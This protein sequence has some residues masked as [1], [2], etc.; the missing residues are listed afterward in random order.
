M[1]NETEDDDDDCGFNDNGADDDDDDNDDDDDD[2]AENKDDDDND[3]NDDDGSDCIDDEGNF[4]DGVTANGDVSNIKHL[5]GETRWYFL[6]HKTLQVGEEIAFTFCTTTSK[7]KN[8]SL[9]RNNSFMNI[10]PNNVQWNFDTIY[11]DTSS[12]SNVTNIMTMYMQFA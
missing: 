7:Q 2:D 10:R 4:V 6:K 8:C 12:R 5:I 9:I 11:L 3:D 1:W